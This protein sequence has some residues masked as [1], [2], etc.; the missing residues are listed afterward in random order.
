MYYILFFVFVLFIT[1]TTD[2]EVISPES[3]VAP[4]YSF[5]SSL[6]YDLEMGWLD[7]DSAWIGTD[8]LGD[9]YQID[10]GS[11]QIVSGIVT[12]SRNSLNGFDH[13]IMSYTVQLSSDG[14]N[15]VDVDGG[16]VFTG[17]SASDD[18]RVTNSFAATVNAR[19]VRIIPETW[20]GYMAMR[21]G[22][23]TG[24]PLS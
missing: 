22:V 13:Y 19:F 5:S 10:L 2:F 7:S 3:T 16:A 21:A 23:V 6:D 8:N 20:N 24:N 9:Y 15:F 11:S 4:S 12:Q 17:N 14:S 1:I 18:V